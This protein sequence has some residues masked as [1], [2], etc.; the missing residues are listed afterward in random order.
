MLVEFRLEPVTEGTR[1]TIVES[2]FD[3][4]PGHR[5]ARAFRMNEDGWAAQVENLRKH[6]DGA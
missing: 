6:V 1:L 2:G 4:V 3:R 5:R